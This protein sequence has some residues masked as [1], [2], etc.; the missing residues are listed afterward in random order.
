M[1]RRAKRAKGFIPIP[2][3]FP[4]RAWY[5]EGNRASFP[6]ERENF[7]RKAEYIMAKYGQAKKRK[8]DRRTLLTRIVAGFIA[9]LMLASVALTALYL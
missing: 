9:L 2:L 1:V 6:R 8:L 3:I 5:Y 7:F 4:R